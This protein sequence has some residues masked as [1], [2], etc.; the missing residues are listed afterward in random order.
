MT[1]V[2]KKSQGRDAMHSQIDEREISYD[3]AYMES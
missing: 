2:A 3:I 1:E